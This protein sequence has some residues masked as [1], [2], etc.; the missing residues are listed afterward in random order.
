MPNLIQERLARERMARAPAEQA[1]T[2][3]M[4]RLAALRRADRRAARA[5]R[6]AQRARLSLLHS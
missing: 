2:M 4:H 5:A 3:R 6:A 1:A